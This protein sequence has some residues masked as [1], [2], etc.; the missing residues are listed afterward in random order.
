MTEEVEIVVTGEDEAPE[1]I[2]TPQYTEIE[3]TAIEQGWRPKDEWQGDESKWRDAKE[4]VE[5]GELYSKIDTMGR[6]LKDTKKALKML[7]EHHSKL[8][9]VEYNKALTELKAAQKK[10]LEAGDADAYLE[11]TELLTDLKAEQKAREVYQEQM[12][13]QVDPRFTAW[14]DKNPWYAK[15]PAMKKHAD[16]IGEVYARQNPD[17]DP[18]EVLQYVTREIKEKFKDKFVNPN[19]AKQ[20][21]EGGSGSAPTSK[22]KFELTA[23]EVKVMNT[24]IRTGA[25]TKEQYIEEVKAMRGTK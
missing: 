7:Q 12:P 20:T 23:D 18:V 17:L 9:E 11:T 6:D 25:M 2:E 21:V 3:Q 22:T 13:E 5:R 8:K 4:F 19:R 14:V 24:F 16:L 10:N 1:V 15:E